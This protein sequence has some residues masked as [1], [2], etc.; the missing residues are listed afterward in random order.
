MTFQPLQPYEASSFSLKG[1]S[2][3]SSAAWPSKLVK[4]GIQ[5]CP[6][7]ASVHQLYEDSYQR[8]NPAPHLL[9]SFHNID[10]GNR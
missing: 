7:A 1:I 6:K 9:N 2:A 3:L 10:A 8:S 5:L 4:A